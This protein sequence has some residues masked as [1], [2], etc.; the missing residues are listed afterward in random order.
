MKKYEVKAV[1]NDISAHTHTHTAG[2][3][4]KSNDLL[5][6]HASDAKQSNYQHEKCIA[7]VPSSPYLHST[8]EQDTIQWRK[9]PHS[10]SRYTHDRLAIG[11]NCLAGHGTCHGTCSPQPKVKAASRW[12]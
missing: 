3:L 11:L 4:Y 12:K 1:S 10:L 5:F 9:Y 7:V 2:M 8:V 6:P